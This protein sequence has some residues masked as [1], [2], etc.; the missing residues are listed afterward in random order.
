[1]ALR[2][3]SSRAAGRVVATSRVLAGSGLAAITVL[4]ALGAPPAGAHEVP[5][6]V[7][8]QLLVRSQGDRLR[9]LVRVPIEAMQEVGIPTTSMGM[10]DLAATRRSDVL[11]DAASLW[12]GDNLEVWAGGDR[13]P[14]LELA[15]V[16]VS[17]PSDRS[18][19]AW[20]TALAHVRA[21]PLPETLQ[22]PW[23]QA[24]LD[25]LFEGSIPSQETELAIRPRFER[26]GLRVRTALTFLPADRPSR[27]YELHGDPGLVRLDPR[28]HQAAGRFVELGF[29]HILGG[30]DHLLFILCL[31]VPLRRLRDLVLVV[32]SFTVAHSVTL[33]ASA[34]G[35][36]PDALWFPPLVE[37]AIAASIVWMAFENILGVGARRRWVITFAFGLVH[38]FGFSFALR[39][40]LQ[41]AGSHLISSLLAFNVGV[42][43]GQVF[44]L[45]LMVPLLDLLLRRVVAERV[46]AILISALVAHTAWHWM[47]ERAATFAQYRI[48]WP[49]VDAIPPR[50]LPWLAVVVV[51]AVPAWR[52]LREVRGRSDSPSAQRGAGEPAVATARP[53]IQTE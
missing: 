19:T 52:A 22:I 9:V 20:D 16:R 46:G 53:P 7:T 43:V 36:A 39:E 38:G 11:A 30:V 25:A 28:W 5:G 4:A 40:T 45:V 34:L 13:L 24:V 44:V 29:F 21:E 10:L 12:I 50:V 1:M 31:V 18:F 15:A 8:V 42:E 23:R 6:D 47:T 33:I 32:T 35:L 27:V 49:L 41:F 37:L 51:L 26:L 2:S 48:D 14:P 3:H 17:L